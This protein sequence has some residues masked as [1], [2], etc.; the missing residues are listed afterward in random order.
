MTVSTPLSR[1]GSD[2]TLLSSSDS[3]SV[4]VAV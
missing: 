3:K 1:S 2:S 4:D